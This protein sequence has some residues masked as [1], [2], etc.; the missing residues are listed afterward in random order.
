[1]DDK[2][3]PVSCPAT[4]L[5]AGANMTCT[6]S[7]TTT[8]ADVSAGSV[9][10]HA[11]ASGTPTSGTLAQATAQ[12]TITFQAQPAWTL[13]KTPTP[14]TYTAAGQSISYSYLLTNSGNVTIN[15]IAISDNKVAP[16]VCPS[17]SLAVGANMTCSGTYITTAGDVTAG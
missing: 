7:Y 10:N 8:A 3:S 17:S 9:V 12:A 4:T 6:G 14:T 1:S 16:V 5:A 2:V 13:A 15:S 11:T